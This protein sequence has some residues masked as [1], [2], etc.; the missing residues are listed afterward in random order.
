[1]HNNYMTECTFCNAD[2][3]SNAEG[4]V[5]K[6]AACCNKCRYNYPHLL[7]C[8]KCGGPDHKDAGTTR[9]DSFYCDKCA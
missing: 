7:M 8:A 4:K 2:F 3:D 5:G 6:S 1:M 9:G